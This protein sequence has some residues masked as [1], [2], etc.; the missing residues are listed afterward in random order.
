MLM[1]GSVAPS[2]EQLERFFEHCLAHSDLDAATRMLK[3]RLAAGILAER[4]PELAE[5]LTDAQV[6]ARRW[7]DAAAL[8]ERNLFGDG[9]AAAAMRFLSRCIDVHALR[10]DGGEF[11]E[12]VE[13][14]FEVIRRGAAGSRTAEGL[15]LLLPQLRRGG[16]HLSPAMLG[17]LTQAW[18]AAHSIEEHD[19][20][21]L[22]A[23][24][25]FTP[26]SA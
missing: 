23:E 5:R 25:G 11:V 16:S 9:T 10:T 4:A 2:R 24:A 22:L 3:V 7:E 6:A 17:M 26:A 15:V 1:E 19:W 13:V 14:A 20:L 12:R 8:I 18:R 21:E